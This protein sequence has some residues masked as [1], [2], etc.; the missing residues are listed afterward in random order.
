MYS[1]GWAQISTVLPTFN[2][3][4]H[5]HL[6]FFLAMSDPAEERLMCA[7]TGGRTIPLGF[8]LPVS[9]Q[10]RQKQRKIKGEKKIIIL[11]MRCLE[12]D[13]S[14]NQS[15]SLRLLKHS[16]LKFQPDC[17]FM[18]IS[19][20]QWLHSLLSSGPL[21]SLQ[22]SDSALHQNSL[23][24]KAGETSRRCKFSGKEK[25]QIFPSLFFFF[26]RGIKKRKKS[27]I[28]RYI[29]ESNLTPGQKT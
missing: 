27:E 10:M 24:K 29:I 1:A 9:S 23:D 16:L 4:A 14:A 13:Q 19:H 12:F 22:I 21:G 20:H 6:P 2:N 25:V 17:T 7:T 5:L 15:P 3:V 18:E 11:R 8:A 28:Q 26:V